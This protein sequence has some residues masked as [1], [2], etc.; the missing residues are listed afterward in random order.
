MELDGSPEEE[1]KWNT[2]VPAP[3]ILRF[4]SSSPI[5]FP[6]VSNLLKMCKGK[7]RE[8]RRQEK[9]LCL[10]KRETSHIYLDR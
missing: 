8:R 9:L 4:S 7:G 3:H 5:F 6:Q 10:K 2:P 1:F